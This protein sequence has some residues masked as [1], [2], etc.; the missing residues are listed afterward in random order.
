MRR[1]ANKSQRNKSADNKKKGAIVFIILLALLLPLAT[2]AQP[3]SGGLKI[4]P[5]KTAT[6]KPNSST[7]QSATKSSGYKKKSG[8]K[9][10]SKTAA[11]MS[12]AERDRI[13]QNLIANMVY[14]EGGTFSMGATPEQQNGSYRS[15]CK[16][17]HCVT[18]SSFEIGKYEVTQAEWQ[19][20]MGSNPSEHKGKNLPVERVDWYDCQKFIRKLNAITGRHFRLPSEA[21]WEYAA[22]GGNRSHGYRYAGSNNLSEVAWYY[23]NSNGMTH[24]VGTKKPNELGLY[25]M[26]G[27]VEE[28]CQDNGLEESDRVVRG[29]VYHIIEFYSGLGYFLVSYRSYRSAK[30]LYPLSSL[31]GNCGLRLVSD[32]MFT[33]II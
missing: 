1:T 23:D 16:S 2:S 14:V 12:K 20:V 18:L 29:G 30:H 22:R 17:T 25:D 3:K 24:P 8:T 31:I 33:K 6:A 28:W 26:C 11:T 32:V 9:S 7:K 27:N 4:P 19:A 15:N 10:G 5:K 13:I 21:E